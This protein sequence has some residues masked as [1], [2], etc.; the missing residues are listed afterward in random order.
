MGYQTIGRVIDGI[1]LTIAA[2]KLQATRIV[3]WVPV[4]SVYRAKSLNRASVQLHPRGAVQA[5]RNTVGSVQIRLDRL[6]ESRY[7]NLTDEENFE[8]IGS[9][10]QAIDSFDMLRFGARLEAEIRQFEI[11]DLE[12]LYLRVQADGQ[13]SGLNDPIWQFLDS[14]A[15][16]SEWFMGTDAA[17]RPE[18]PTIN[19]E[20]MRRR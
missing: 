9:F 15:V 5:G 14:L 4:G 13:V 3:L 11:L 2:R 7:P 16:S 1:G 10:G 18:K 19:F 17:P 6:V 12:Q 8:A 20:T